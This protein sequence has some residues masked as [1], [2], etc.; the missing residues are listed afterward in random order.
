HERV[1]LVAAED[2]WWRTPAPVPAGTDYLF[3]LDGGPGLPD[4]RSGWQ[5]HGV[6]GPSRV[7]DVAAH[8][9][10]DDSWAGRSALGAVCYELH[11][12]TFTPEGTLDAAVGRLD[13]LVDLG[14]DIAERMPVAPFPGECG[15]GYDGVS[16]YAVH[17]PYGGPQ[18]L[19]RFV[20]AAHGRG[21]AVCLD[22][23]YN[24]LGPS[25]NYLGRFG[26]YFTDRHE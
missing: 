25:G 13:H 23:V 20:D 8:A 15:W 10:R 22:V 26:P 16:L 19:Q 5:P 24:H 12:G 6:H 9:W 2:G 17:Q 1:G 4:P 3:H 21:L 7:F 11:V 14:V 18:A